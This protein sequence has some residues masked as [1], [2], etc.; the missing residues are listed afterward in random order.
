MKSIFSLLFILSLSLPLSAQRYMTA[1]GV[2]IGNSVGV[3][4]TQ[5]ILPPVTGELIIQNDLKNS[6]YLHLLGRYHRPL[7]TKGF[8]AYFGGGVHFGNN[9]EL[10]GVAGLDGIMGLELN[11]KR[12]SL[13][14]DLKPQWTSGAGNGLMLNSAVSI[15]YIILK[16]NFL[17]QEGRE[18]LRKKRDRRRKRAGK[19]KLNKGL[20]DS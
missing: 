17:T 16:D 6:T 13:S 8:N 9:N 7:L 4:L 18:K 5:R 14:A 1:M 15:R 19:K 12:L 2:R 11:L 20:F 10:G 3:S